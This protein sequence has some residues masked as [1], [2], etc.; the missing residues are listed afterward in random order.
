MNTAP[1]HRVLTLVMISTLALAGCQKSADKPAAPTQ[2]TSEGTKPVAPVPAPAPEQ[3]PAPQAPPVPAEAPP[4]TSAS[5]P[6]P[7]A[8]PGVAKS[9]ATTRSKV[10]PVLRAV[11]SARQPNADRVVFEFNSVGLPAW[12]AEYVER[13]VTACGSGDPVAVAGTAV[14]QITFNGAQ[15]HNEQGR[16]T[17]GNRRRAL[18]LKLGRELVRTCD[19]EGEVT[20]V[21]GVTQA[22]PFTARAMSAPSRLVIDIAH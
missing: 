13:P 12:Q 18:P 9:R 2:A 21:I 22:N 7:G 20:W 3:T 16:S 8:K 15:A 17:S 11:R 14:L 1:S 5:A 10:P 4:Q 6:A 19:F